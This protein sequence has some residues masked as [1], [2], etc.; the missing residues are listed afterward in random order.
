MHDDWV[1]LIKRPQKHLPLRKSYFS[2]FFFDTRVIFEHFVVFLEYFKH[3]AMS[4]D[5]VNCYASIHQE[6]HF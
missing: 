4:I 3:L 2:L 1:A 5:T 6:T